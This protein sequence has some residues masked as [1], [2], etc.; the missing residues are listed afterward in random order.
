[1]KDIL[2]QVFGPIQCKEGW[3][4]RSNKELWILIKGKDIVKCIQ[5]QRMIDIKL[6]KKM[7][8]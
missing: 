7:T 4:I 6:V 1:L 8:D 3:R 5:A 2:R